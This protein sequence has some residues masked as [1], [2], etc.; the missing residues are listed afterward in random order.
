MVVRLALE[1]LVDSLVIELEY[2]S[3]PLGKNY[4][5]SSRQMLQR[6]PLDS[7]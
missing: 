5:L 2:T 7:I 3:S 4:R 6:L 1:E